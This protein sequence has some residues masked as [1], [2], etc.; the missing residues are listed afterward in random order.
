[1]T[2]INL[3]YGPLQEK[4]NHLKELCT[5]FGLPVKITDTR[6]DQAEQDALYA[7]GR[8]TPGSIVTNAKYPTSAHNWGLAFDF[9]RNVPGKEY[10]D[11]DHFFKKVGILG[12]SIGLAWG[13][14]WQSF[15]DKPH[16]EYAEL[17]PSNSVATIRAKYGTPE[18]FMKTWEPSESFTYEVRGGIHFVR[19]PIKQFKLMMWDKNKRTTAIKNYANGGFFGNYSEE[20]TTFTLPEANLMADLGD[21]SGWPLRY[22]KER[23]TVTDKKVCIQRK[24][25]D[26]PVSTLIVSGDTAKIIKT[27]TL[28]QGCTYAISGIPIIRGGEDVSFKNDVL[29][30]GWDA[31]SLY[32]TWHGF[33]TI[34][35]NSI[36]YMGFKTTSS[37]LVATAE[38]YKKLKKYGFQDVIKIDG[39]GSFILDVGGVNK[40]VTTGKR[41]INN[42]IL[43]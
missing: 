38:A 43:F 40:A 28:P 42:V 39:G 35:G 22:L 31:S 36:L 33:L 29:P 18:V 32:G 37:N 17:L 20:A 14:D 5:L 6:R 1:M 19:T 4:L 3:L 12:K 25:S 7:Q 23:G 13:G 10:D 30:E 26:T 41:Q 15:V 8:T 2:D 34:D 27:A 21:V 9:C 24:A 16:L 11:S